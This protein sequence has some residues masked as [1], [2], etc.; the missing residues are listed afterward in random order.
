MLVQVAWK[1][2]MGRLLFISHE[3]VSQADPDPWGENQN[4]LLCSYGEDKLLFFT[5]FSH[6]RREVQ[7][8]LVLC[9]RQ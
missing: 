9:D 5:D 3:W 7:L 1:P 8:A 6:G 4:S 2:E